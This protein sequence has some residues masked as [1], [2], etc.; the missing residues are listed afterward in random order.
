ME[1]DISSDSD[2][3]SP[4]IRALRHHDVS[5][6]LAM[7]ALDLAKFSWTLYSKGMIKA[8]DVEKVSLTNST[9]AEK[10]STLLSAIKSGIDAEVGLFKELVVSLKEERIKFA[11]ELESTCGKLVY[12]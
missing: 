10:S 7:T 12:I 4:E 11:E 3:A 5:F 1:E 2:N 9:M 8:S 6:S